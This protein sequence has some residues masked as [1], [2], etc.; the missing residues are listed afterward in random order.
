M[1]QKKSNSLVVSVVSHGHQP[2]VQSLL[3]DLARDC[4]ASVS[5][6]VLTLN[7]PEQAPCPPP[8]GWPF[9]LHVRCNSVP[10]GF[11]ANHN[12]ALADAEE[13]CIGVLNPD[14]RLRRGDPFAAML[15]VAESQSACVYP[16]QFGEQGEL[17]ACEREIPTPWSLLRR[18]LLGR[19]ER[20]TEW[21][22][23]ACLVM[24]Q[25]VWRSLN[26]FNEAYFMYCEDV[27]LCLRARLAGYPLVRAEAIV[28]HGGQ[29]ASGKSFR[30]FAWHVRSLIRLWSSPVFWRAR[31]LL[32]GGGVPKGRIGPP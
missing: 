30:H 23:A 19:K 8:G 10:L 24:P 5:R 7:I 9:V 12:R 28:E 20:S 3:N 29:R 4:W 16:L 27:D 22:N 6:V 13:A 15:S 21:V 18:R 11:G 14:V 32:Q 17:Q 26:G 31:H 1:L 2:M 25:G